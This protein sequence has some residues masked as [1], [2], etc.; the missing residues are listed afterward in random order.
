VGQTLKGVAD[1]LLRHFVSPFTGPA[2]LLASVEALVLE[3]WINMLAVVGVEGLPFPAAGRPMLLAFGL[4]I[5]RLSAMLPGCGITEMVATAEDG[6][7]NILRLAEEVASL[8]KTSS[9]APKGEGSLIKS[10][11]ESGKNAAR[12]SPMWVLNVAHDFAVDD[13]GASSGQVLAK[14]RAMDSSAG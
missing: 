1:V 14:L 3:V 4:G 9:A 11:G 2:E 5:S 6:A 12:A 10:T 7:A 8:R 13:A